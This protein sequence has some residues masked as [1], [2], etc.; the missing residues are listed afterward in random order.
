M[1]VIP[2]TAA[3]Y[4][5]AMD[6]GSTS[7][8]SLVIS[9]KQIN[10]IYLRHAILNSVPSTDLIAREVICFFTARSLRLLFHVSQYI[11][12][13]CTYTFILFPSLFFFFYR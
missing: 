1:L 11:C 5:S 6:Y 13:V 2:V 10:V 12:D 8:T 3:K 7:S 4:T 9:R